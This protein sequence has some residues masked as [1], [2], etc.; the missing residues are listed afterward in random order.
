MRVLLHADLVVKLV[1]HNI[2]KGCG[3]TPLAMSAFKTYH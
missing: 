3:F 1:L 2:K